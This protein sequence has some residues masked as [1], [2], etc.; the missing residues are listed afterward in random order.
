LTARMA[1]PSPENGTQAA[2]G[3]DGGMLRVD[4]DI[5]SSID[6][7]ANP[8]H[9]GCSRNRRKASGRTAEGGTGEGKR[10]RAGPVNRRNTACAARRRS[11]ERV[12]KGT[13]P[14]TH[15]APFSIAGPVARVRQDIWF[16][17]RACVPLV[18]FPRKGSPMKS[19]WA[20]LRSP[21]SVGGEVPGRPAGLTRHYQ[22][23][24]RLWTTQRNKTI[25]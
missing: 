6:G 14:G 22:P 4:T 3:S 7:M 19:G 11:R 1:C 5:E 9:A 8:A 18:A 12:S 16:D 24:R 10:K 25:Q 20:G 21:L 15:G 17:L 13:G 23:R 2:A